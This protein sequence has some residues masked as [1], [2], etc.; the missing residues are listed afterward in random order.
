MLRESINHKSFTGGNEPAKDG[1]GEIIFIR[2]PRWD[3]YDAFYYL[4]TSDAAIAEARQEA[5]INRIT[6]ENEQLNSILASYVTSAGADSERDGHKNAEIDRMTAE[7]K[8]HAEHIAHYQSLLKS[9]G[10]ENVK[11]TASLAKCQA[12]RDELLTALKEIEWSNNEQWRTDRAKQ[13]IAAIEG[14]KNDK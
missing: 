12:E 13:A 3:S 10:E 4:D 14:E 5:K 8:E 1:N 9:I 2:L 6:H 11:L 7:A